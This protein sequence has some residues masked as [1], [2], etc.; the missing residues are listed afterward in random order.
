MIEYVIIAFVKFFNWDPLTSDNEFMKK[1]T[2]K[3]IKNVHNIVQDNKST[4]S[5]PISGKG[6]KSKV[7]NGACKA[8]M[9]GQ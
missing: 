9:Q 6:L 7:V 2:M 3:L 8:L 4:I 5:S 1:K